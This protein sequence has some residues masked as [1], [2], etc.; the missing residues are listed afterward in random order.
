MVTVDQL[1]RARLGQARRYVGDG[2]RRVP[3][4]VDRQETAVER[5]L[6]A[7]EAAQHRIQHVDDAKV[8]P[9]QQRRDVGV[10]IDGDAL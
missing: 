1:Q 7:K 3:H 4:C 5:L 9:G 6:K 8:P 2:V 10:E